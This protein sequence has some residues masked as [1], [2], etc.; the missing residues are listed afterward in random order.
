MNLERIVQ[1]LQSLNAKRNPQTNTLVIAGLILLGGFMTYNFVGSQLTYVESMSKKPAVATPKPSISV[2]PTPTP[3][4][5]DA[6]V[7]FSFD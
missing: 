6:T 3:D 5:S 4:Q 2:S 1:K 7:P